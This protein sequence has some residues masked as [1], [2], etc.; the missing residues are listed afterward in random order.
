MQE[1]WVQSLVRELRSTCL[2]GT[3]SPCA[4]TKEL[5]ERS[6][7]LQLRSDAAK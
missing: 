6:H 1:V 7:M 4:R 2:E 3:I 5:K